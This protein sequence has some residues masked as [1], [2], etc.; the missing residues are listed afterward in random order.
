MRLEFVRLSASDVEVIHEDSNIVMASGQNHF[1][2]LLLSKCVGVG[3]K[4]RLLQTEIQ[5]QCN[6]LATDNIASDHSI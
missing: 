2:S 1:P 6:Q 5:V 3:S 4:G